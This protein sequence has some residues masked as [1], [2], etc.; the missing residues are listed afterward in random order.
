MEN[1]SRPRAPH[2]ARAQARAVDQ[3]HDAGD[4]LNRETRPSDRMRM[5]H[6]RD[7]VPSGSDDHAPAHKEVIGQAARDLA[8]GLRDTDCRGQAPAAARTSSARLRPGS[9]CPPARLGR[10]ARRMRRSGA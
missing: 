5:P 2:P 7:E 10:A 8:N 9:A 1:R 6:E 3:Q 4:A